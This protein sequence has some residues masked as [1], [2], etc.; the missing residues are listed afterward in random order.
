MI[1]V[2]SK[3]KVF[4]LTNP[5]GTQV[6]NRQN[7]INCTGIVMN[8]IK[9]PGSGRR[10]MV[11]FDE[12]HRTVFWYAEDELC[13]IVTETKVMAYDSANIANREIK[14]WEK[15]NWKMVDLVI[16]PGSY[17][18]G[19]TCCLG[20]LF[21]PLALLGKKQDK[22]VVTFRREVAVKK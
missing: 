21:L 19:K 16:Q 10:C 13:E 5:V 12:S 9:I 4:I 20:A 15:A 17:D 8:V 11:S 22:C 14:K 1:Q 6:D 18:A 7:T 2:G 3:V